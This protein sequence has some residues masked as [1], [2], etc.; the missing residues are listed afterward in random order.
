MGI[1]IILLCFLATAVIVLWN[2]RKI[3]K[4]METIE[5]MLDAAMNVSYLLWKKSLRTIFPQQ[6][7][8]LK[9]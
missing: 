6:K 5:N 1:A 9:M 4:T 8:P 3:R 2:Q 7:L